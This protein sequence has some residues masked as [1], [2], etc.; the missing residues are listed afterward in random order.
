MPSDSDNATRQSGTSVSTS[1]PDSVTT[2]AS[3]F[4]CNV[5]L[6]PK[7]EVHSTNLSKEWKQWRQVW[8]AYEEVTD[9]RNK[10]SCRRVATFITLLERKRLKFTMVFRLQARK[11]NPT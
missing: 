10:P 6:P 4:M 7:L 3:S 9:L 1:I 8:D 2:M 5:S 11:R